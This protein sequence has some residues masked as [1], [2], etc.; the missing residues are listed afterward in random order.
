MYFAVPGLFTATALYGALG[1][2][3]KRGRA[4]AVLRSG[5]SHAEGIHDEGRRHPVADGPTP[6]GTPE[7][8]RR[9]LVIVP[10][11]NEAANVERLV[12]RIRE[13]C[14]FD[15]CVVDDRSPDGTGELADR[16]AA[17]PANR[18]VV[19]HRAGRSGRGGAVFAGLQYGLANDYE[20]CVEM[21]ADLSHPPEQLP[22]LVAGLADVDVVIGSRYEEDSRI[23]GWPLRRRLFSRSANRFSRSV[24]R[25]PGVSDY[26]NGFRAYGRPACSVIVESGLGETGYAA[27]AEWILAIHVAGLSARSI[28]TRFMDRTKGQS[29][30]NVS[31]VVA[32]FR[33][34]I[35]LRLGLRRGA[36]RPGMR[37]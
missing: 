17:D 24:L 28:P 1:T 4:R 15:L 13:A 14:P 33:A 36:S 26:S 35:R 37:P 16:L 21:D 23:T 18:M 22:D 32:A 27:L 34:V 19:L 8:G 7:S 9:T 12:A 29:K 5:M 31:E 30:A 11:Y 25:V 3:D 6:I 2:R 20:A 10:T